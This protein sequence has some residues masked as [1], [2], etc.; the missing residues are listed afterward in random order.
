MAPILRCLVPR[1][2]SPTGVRVVSQLPNGIGQLRTD[3]NPHSSML[4]SSRGGHRAVITDRMLSH[5][6][7][8]VCCSE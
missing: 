7:S 2:A 5:C 6:L 3:L 1:F 8:N 4:H